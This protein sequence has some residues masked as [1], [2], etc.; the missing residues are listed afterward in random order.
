M[1]TLESV[2]WHILGYGAM[3]VIILSGFVAVAAI[4]LW[5]LSFGKDKE[6]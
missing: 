1:S 6:V 3:P 2:I 5:L 4:S